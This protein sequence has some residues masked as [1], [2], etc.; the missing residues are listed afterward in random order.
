LPLLKPTSPTII[1]AMMDPCACRFVADV[2]S[3]PMDATTVADERHEVADVTQA[4]AI[5]KQVLGDWYAH[6]AEADLDA[7]AEAEARNQQKLKARG[8]PVTPAPPVAVRHQV[9]QASSASKMRQVF[10][11]GAG[12]GAG[13]AGGDQG[14]ELQRDVQARI[15]RFNE[16]KVEGEANVTKL[17]N[18]FVSED[19]LKRF[20]APD[21]FLHSLD[22][23]A[24][25]GKARHS[26]RRADADRPQQKLVARN[27]VREM[28]TMLK[29][30]YLDEDGL[31]SLVFEGAVAAFGRLRRLARCVLS[32][33]AMSA[34]AESVFSIA[35]QLDTPLRNQL[36]EDRFEKLLIASFVL[37]HI[38]RVAAEK[39]SNKPVLDFAN[40]VSAQ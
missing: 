3:W 36:S 1:A 39:N 15:N 30:F 38:K 10:G 32:T 40:A 29:K 34:A 17:C 2:I 20:E 25:A 28:Q 4:M 31:Q 7:K 26:A 23:L 8:P 24:A 16:L 5:S 35:G 22:E 11:A 33:T 27:K 9:S 6:V 37:R 19:F 12:A 21:T 18:E 14:G 13:D